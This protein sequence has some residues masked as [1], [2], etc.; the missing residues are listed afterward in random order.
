MLYKG[1]E[2]TRQ[3]PYDTSRLEGNVFVTSVS[4]KNVCIKMTANPRIKT[5]IVKEKPIALI[6]SP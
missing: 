2:E 4:T 3:I 1:N 6:Q 5:K